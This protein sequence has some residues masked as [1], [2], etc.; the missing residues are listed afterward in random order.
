MNLVLGWCQGYMGIQ[1]HMED[2]YAEKG[3]DKECIPNPEYA[4]FSNRYVNQINALNHTKDIDYCFIGSINS[5]AGERQWVLDFCKLYFTSKSVFVNTDIQPC[6]YDNY[7]P[8]GNYDYTKEGHGFNP[9]FQTD[10]QC[11]TSQLRKV[12]ENRF[13]FESMCRSKYCLCPAGDAPWSF[14]FYEILMCKS[15]P[16]VKS[17]HDTYRTEQESK[18]P[19]QFI[20]QSDADN[21]HRYPYQEFIHINHELFQKYHML[22]T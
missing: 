18:I 10:N 14:R 17:W 19:Y 2:A 6:D 5:N 1:Y 15:V 11:R 22:P 7:Q 8:L 12:E 4:I 3:I 9:K 21:I 16:V 13:Y 20:L